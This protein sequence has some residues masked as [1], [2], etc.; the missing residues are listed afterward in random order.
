MKRVALFLSA[1]ALL[2]CASKPEMNKPV[3]VVAPGL[4]EPAP[5]IPYQDLKKGLK[6]IDQIL[7]ST[8]NRKPALDT[9]GRKRRDRGDIFNRLYNEKSGGL[10]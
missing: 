2:G 5:A 8:V 10:W 4:P 7:A 9:E 6:E 3:Q 1:F